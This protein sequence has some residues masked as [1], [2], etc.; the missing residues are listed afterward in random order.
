MFTFDGDVDPPV[1]PTLDPVDPPADPPQ[2][3]PADPDPDTI[4]M[5]K[6][7]RDQLIKDTRKQQDKRWKGR[8]KL[9]DDAPGP[10]DDEPPHTPTNAEAERVDRLELKQEGIKNKDQQD[11]V[12]DYAR[13]KK[14]SI[15]EALEAPTVKAILKEMQDKAATPPPSRRTGGATREDIDYWVAE[16]KRGGKSAPTLEMRRKVRRAIQN[17][18]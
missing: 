13:T 14:I 16:Y 4:T 18:A 10:D 15:G 5:T 3:P 9:P 1:D 11:A 8:L 17:G 6:A 12:L 7:E 2:D